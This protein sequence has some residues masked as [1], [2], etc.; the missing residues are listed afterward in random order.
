M[1]KRFGEKLAIVR[2][3][4]RYAIGMVAS[5]AVT[6]W[7]VWGIFHWTMLAPFYVPGGGSATPSTARLIDVTGIWTFGFLTALL[8][9]RVTAD[10]KSYPDSAFIQKLFQ[11]GILFAWLALILGFPAALYTG[12]AVDA[13]RGGAIADAIAVLGSL[14]AIRFARARRRESDRLSQGGPSFMHVKTTVDSPVFGL[15]QNKLQELP[16]LLLLLLGTVSWAYGDVVVHLLRSFIGL[17]SSCG[18]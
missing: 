8:S 4:W 5:G 3:D 15:L 7:L 12:C 11:R 1:G 13:G 14:M 6:L 16:F 18:G 17:S 2:H 10:W 9:V